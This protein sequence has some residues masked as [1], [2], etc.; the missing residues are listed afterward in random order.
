MNRIIVS[1]LADAQNDSDDKKA[2]EQ[3]LV[4]RYGLTGDEPPV[5]IAS[6][7]N[8]HGPIVRVDKLLRCGPNIRSRGAGLGTVAAD[9]DLS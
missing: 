4:S 7:P 5:G 6:R 8:V 9:V 1:D 3:G 2:E